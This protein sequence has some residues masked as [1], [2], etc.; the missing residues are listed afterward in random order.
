LWWRYLCLVV[1]LLNNVLADSQRKLLLLR[2]LLVPLLILTI[3]G[4]IIGFSLLFLRLSAALAT[5]YE[6][7]KNV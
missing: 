5:G 2:C 3:T 6:E 4:L 1:R 7:R